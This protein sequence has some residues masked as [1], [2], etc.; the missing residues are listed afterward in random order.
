M[1][2]AL[3]PNL[4]P[5]EAK[6]PTPTLTPDTQHPSPE[7]AQPRTTHQEERRTDKLPAESPVQAR[8][9]PHHLLDVVAEPVHTCA[10]TGQA[11]HSGPCRAWG[12]PY[13]LPKRVCPQV[14]SRTVS[15]KT[16]IPWHLGDLGTGTWLVQNRGENTLRGSIPW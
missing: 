15:P 16:G 14:D 9:E 11:H 4:L 13:C 8:L 3:H 1:T 6:I 10:H 5:L 2:R 7:D 12:H